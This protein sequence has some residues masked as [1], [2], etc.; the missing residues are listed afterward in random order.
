MAGLG[1]EDVARLANV[2]LPTLRRIEAG[3]G[4]PSE[5]ANDMAMVRSALE[6]A[7][8]EFTNGSQPGVRMKATA[9]SSRGAAAISDEAALPE[10]P[11]NDL[12]PY[13]GSPV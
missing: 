1:Q 3:D 12:E 10:I 9:L 4:A 8:V 2:S 6:A 11:E 13:D 5:L 7:G